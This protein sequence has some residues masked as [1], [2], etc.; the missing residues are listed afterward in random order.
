M[1]GLIGQLAD[2]EYNMH[3]DPERLRAS[4]YYLE[5]DGNTYE[6]NSIGADGAVV[7]VEGFPLFVSRDETYRANINWF[8]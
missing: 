4:R 7:S 3:L 8:E 2:A 1:R 5:L 6:G